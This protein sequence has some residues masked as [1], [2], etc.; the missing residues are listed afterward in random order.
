MSDI[1]NLSAWLICYAP[2]PWHG[3]LRERSN[4]HFGNFFKKFLRWA[5]GL[6]T[7][8]AVRKISTNMIE[9]YDEKATKQFRRDDP[10]QEI[11]FKSTADESR[12]RTLWDDSRRRY[13]SIG[14]FVRRW[15]VNSIM[16][17]SWM[18]LDALEKYKHLLYAE[19]RCLHMTWMR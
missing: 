7:T 9:A 15:G 17:T 12:I 3:R 8:T 5:E 16:G 18:T 10:N 4:F 19:F 2:Y 14:Y 11:R 6:Q 13:I 1:R